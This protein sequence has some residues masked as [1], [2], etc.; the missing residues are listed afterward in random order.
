M[1]TT[2]HVRRRPSFR[3]LARPDEDLNKV[4]QQIEQIVHQALYEKHP[5]TSSVPL[6]G[7]PATRHL[8]S[9]GAQNFVD[10]RMLDLYERG[11]MGP[12]LPKP[13]VIPD[14]HPL[15]NHQ[16]AQH[17]ERLG[18]LPLTE[19]IKSFP[20]GVKLAFAR[21]SIRHHELVHKEGV[22]TDQLV[23]D[24]GEEF[25]GGGKACVKELYPVL[26]RHNGLIEHARRLTNDGG[27]VAEALIGRAERVSELSGMGY[28][29]FAELVSGPGEAMLADRP[30]QLKELQAAM[31]DVLQKNGPAAI[32]SQVKQGFFQDREPG[33]QDIAPFKKRCENVGREWFRGHPEQLEQFRSEMRSFIEHLR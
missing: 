28:R 24:F 19:M 11:E 33:R 4:E 6:R 32:F 9:R 12:P 29:H 1:A 31:E 7:P 3:P 8:C 5:V 10:E 20:V 14:D 22:W 13:M 17:F 26:S 23:A 18:D 30:Q 21:T 25:A 2:T 15:R 27:A 16:G